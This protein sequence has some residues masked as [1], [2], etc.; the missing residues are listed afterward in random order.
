MK[1]PM[2][3]R[4]MAR[5][6]LKKYLEGRL[7]PYI[8]RICKTVVENGKASTQATLAVTQL[9]HDSIAQIRV[10]SMVTKGMRRATREQKRLKEALH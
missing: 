8:N 2:R 7:T 3:R 6:A 9:V 1:R 10:Y 5:G 4:R